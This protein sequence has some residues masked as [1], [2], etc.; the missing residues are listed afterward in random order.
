MSDVNNMS[1]TE[2][3]NISS[4]N[5]RQNDSNRHQDPLND[6]TLTYQV[7]SGAQVDSI[8]PETLNKYSMPCYFCKKLIHKPWYHARYEIIVCRQCWEQKYKGTDW[9]NNRI[10]WTYPFDQWYSENIGHCV[11]CGREFRQWDPPAFNN[12]QKYCSRK[13]KIANFIKTRKERNEANLKKLC[14]YCNK[15]FVAARKDAKYCCAN[16]RVMACMKREHE[17]NSFSQ[18]SMSG[19]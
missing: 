2:Q 3:I 7:P 1:M 19:E 10:T 9:D 6:N 17:K 12:K 8:E 14:S 11:I 5:S 18:K 13:C 4:S 15:Q 16:H